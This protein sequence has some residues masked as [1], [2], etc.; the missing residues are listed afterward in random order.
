MTNIFHTR[1]GVFILRAV[2][3]LKTS[4]IVSLQTKANEE[5]HKKENFYIVSKYA[6]RVKIKFLRE[7][8]TWLHLVIGINII[9]YIFYGLSSMMIGSVDVVVV[10]RTPALCND[11][12]SHWS[13]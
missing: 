4:S 13:C 6:L 7:E 3:I 9:Y 1:K 10:E 2:N 5:Q 11:S 12:F 8:R